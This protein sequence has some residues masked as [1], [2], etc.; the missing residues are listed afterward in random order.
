MDG[1]YLI[2][3]DEFKSMGTNW[4]ALF[5]NGKNII[6]FNSFVAEHIPKEIHK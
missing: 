2:H 6:Y 5:V 1:V 4:I 3:L